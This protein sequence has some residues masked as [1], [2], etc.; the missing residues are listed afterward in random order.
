[1][2][3]VVDRIEDKIAILH[4][5]QGGQ[6]VNIPVALLPE[7]TREGDWLN[8][9]ITADKEKTSAMYMKNKSLLD[10]LKRKNQ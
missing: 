9:R 2:K 6:F 4:F 10:K 1:M 7:G 5:E 8:I 3:A